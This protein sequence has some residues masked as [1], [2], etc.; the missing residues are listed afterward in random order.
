MCRNVR[1][2]RSPASDTAGI[3]FAVAMLAVAAM[4]LS[5]CGLRGERGASEPIP[6]PSGSGSR[7]VDSSLTT[8]DGRTREYRLFLPSALSAAGTAPLEPLPLVIALHGGVGS[9][10]QFARNSGF[11]ELAEREQVIIVYPDGTGFAG[12]EAL[13]TWNAGG[14]CG[15]AMKN[16]VD[17]VGFVRQLIETIES[18]YAIDAHRVYA[19]GHSNGGMLAYRLACELSDKIV[20]IGVQSATL[21]AGPCDPVKPVSVIDIQGSADKNVPIG[22]GKGEGLSGAAYVAPINA[23]KILAKA[24]GCPADPVT[25]TDPVNPDVTAQTWQPCLDR[26][27]VDYVTVDGA[28]HAWMGR[29]GGAPALTG[30]PYLDFDSTA[31]IWEFLKAHPRP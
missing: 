3:A 11:D 19:A 8:A 20:G 31:A 26:S 2:D 6:A 21:M 14:C 29:S 17:D 10:E 12:S 13:R 4:A 24:D 23:V 25:E 15:P 7:V 28:S 9:G 27:A 18:D 22:G 1:G 16:N 5:A 30:E